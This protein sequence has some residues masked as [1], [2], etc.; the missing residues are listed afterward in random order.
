MNPNNS[1]HVCGL[2]IQAR[3]SALAAVTQ[4]LLSW[5]DSDIAAQDAARGTLAVTL[6][7]SDSAALLNNIEA[8]RNIPGVLAVSLVYHQQDESQELA[9]EIV[10]N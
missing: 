2:V 5:A 1:W 3:P 8:T 10:C 7:A 4:E 9:R 6:A